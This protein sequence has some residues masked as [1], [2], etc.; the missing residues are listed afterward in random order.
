MHYH[1]CTMP[2][3]AFRTLKQEECEAAG[4]AYTAS[5]GWMI[6]AWVHDDN[7]LGVFSMWNPNV[8]PLILGTAGIRATRDLGRRS[9]EGEVNLAIQNF[10][11]PTVEVPPG[12]SVT[13]VNVDGVPHTV[14]TGSG[15]VADGG[16]DSSLIGPGQSF[17][18]EFRER[19]RFVY[20]CTLH[21]QMNATVIVE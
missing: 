8:P 10:A 12:T 7:P 2:V 19:G 9:A 5:S 4:G 6:H 21:P 1:L 17:T 14:T 15:G 18:Y 11:H 3:G 16:F 20:T 13:W